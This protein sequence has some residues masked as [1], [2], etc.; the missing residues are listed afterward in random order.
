MIKPRKVTH[1][2]FVV[3]VIAFADFHSSDLCQSHLQVPPK[4]VLMQRLTAS[5]HVALNNKCISRK[6]KIIRYNLKKPTYCV[7]CGTYFK[8][9]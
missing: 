7:N 2:G 3:T 4:S 6:R 9:G 5:L 1:Y 8:F